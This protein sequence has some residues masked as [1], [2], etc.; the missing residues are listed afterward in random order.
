MIYDMVPA[1]RLGLDQ[2]T[3]FP[4]DDQQ[5]NR[6]FENTSAK[7]MD[8][9]VLDSYVQEQT[10]KRYPKTVQ[11][12]FDKDDTHIEYTISEPKEINVINIY[13]DA[14]A[15]ARSKFDQIRMRPTYTRYLAQAKLAIP[16]AR[17]NE[18][19]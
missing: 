3:L 5:G 13:G 8:I 2:V 1:E 19:L 18:R 4:V 15:A 17:R 7:G 6:V 16:R 11:Y 14:P 12:T 10:G 9:T